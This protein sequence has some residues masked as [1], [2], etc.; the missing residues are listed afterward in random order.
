VYT[1]FVEKVKLVTRIPKQFSLHFYDY[2]VISS[3]S[4]KFQHF[5][6][7]YEESTFDQDLEFSFRFTN[8]FLNC[9]PPH[10]HA[11]SVAKHALHLAICWVVWLTW[12][13]TVF[14]NVDKNC[15]FAAH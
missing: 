6:S 12:N 15:L 7:I 8:K 11:P 13:D 9:F 1:C 14:H 3:G 2:Y 5:E 10:N 4:Y